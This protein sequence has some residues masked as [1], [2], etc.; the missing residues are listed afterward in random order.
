[1][2]VSQQISGQPVYFRGSQI[3]SLSSKHHPSTRIVSAHNVMLEYVTKRN[4]GLF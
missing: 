3:F 2:R 1:M 4:G